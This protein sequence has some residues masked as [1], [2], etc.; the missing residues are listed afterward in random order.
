MNNTYGDIF[1]GRKI[2]QLRQHLDSPALYIGI[3]IDGFTAKTRRDYSMVLIHFVVLNFPPSIRY[4]NSYMMN[5][6]MIPGPVAPKKNQ[7]WK[8]LAPL[9][10]ELLSLEKHGIAVVCDD[11]ISRRMKVY[12]LFISGDLP[13]ISPIAGHAGHT[14]FSPCRICTIQGSNML[15]SSKPGRYI[16]P[17]KTSTMRIKQHFVRGDP[18]VR[19]LHHKQNAIFTF[20]FFRTRLSAHQSPNWQHLQERA[21]FVWTNYTTFVWDYV[22]NCTSY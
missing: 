17:L 18:K 1:T 9:L 16:D 10:G 22:D 3:Y 5:Y 4:K 8:F 6:A 11:G 12:C 13:G 2:I 19:K 7:Y 15:D 20:F 21:I 14:S